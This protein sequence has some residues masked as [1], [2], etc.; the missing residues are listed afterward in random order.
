MSQMSQMSG[1]LERAVALISPA[2][3]VL[4]T[5]HL[6]PDGDA[7]GSMSALVA[8]LREQG[9]EAT[10][11]NPD[12]LPRALRWLPHAKS[13]KKK[14]SATARFD[15]TIV[16]DCGDRR[17]L[18]DAFPPPEVTGP[19]LA[20]DHHAHARP[21]GDVFY[22][23]PQ[24]SAVGVL[25]ARIAR[26][27]GWPISADAAA[28]IYLAIATDTGWF[29]YANTTAETFALAAELVGVSGADPREIAARVTEEFSVGRYRLL[30]R[31]LDG[32]T[33]ELGGKVALLTITDEMVRAAGAIWSDTDGFVNYAR[34]LA[35]VECGVLLTPAKGGGARVS[36]RAKRGPIDAG[37]ICALLG[38]GGH[39]GAAG[40]RVT[41]TVEEARVV[42]LAALAAALGVAAPAVSTAAPP[43]T[44]TAAPPATPTVA[45]E[46]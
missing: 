33:L 20:L 7:A 29:R 34:A 21:F 16:V 1:D 41:G 4:V 45:V 11:Y 43:A 36:L 24:A 30:A 5:A 8:M 2:R 13:Q 39:A 6:G 32:M 42:V 27:L 17:L 10:F 37:A 38:G 25:V 18:G 3:R 15:L 19:V 14:L 31:V 35:G 22:T 9:R 28:G 46:S 26:A 23:D 12:P 40:C 44:P